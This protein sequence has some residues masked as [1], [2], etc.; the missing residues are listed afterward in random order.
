M[1]FYEGWSGLYGGG[2][3]SSGGLFLLGGV[4]VS[5]FNRMYFNVPLE[6]CFKVGVSFLTLGYYIALDLSLQREHRLA[7]RI[8][9]GEAEFP[10]NGKSMPVT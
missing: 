6:N 2:G 10:K 9:L 8:I 4:V 7:R 3:G 5:V 1:F